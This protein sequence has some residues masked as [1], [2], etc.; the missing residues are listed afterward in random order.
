MTREQ[1]LWV[2]NEFKE[3]YSL[4]PGVLEKKDPDWPDFL[5]TTSNGTKIGIEL[6]EIVDSDDVQRDYVTR[7]KITDAV[8]ERLKPKMPFRFAID[9]E[10]LEMGVSKAQFSATVDALVSFC[11]SE[12]D[13]LANN[14]KLEFMR[15]D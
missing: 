14:E 3:L 1:E 12:F 9:I 7:N 4:P 8:L 10:L 11:L 13:H 2:M 5:L 15:F 6:T